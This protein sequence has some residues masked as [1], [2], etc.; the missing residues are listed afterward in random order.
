[1]AKLTFEGAMKRLEAIVRELETGDLGLD[2]A[3]KRFQEGIKLSRFCSKKLDESEKK[4]TLLLQ[5][6]TGEVREEPFFA[7]SDGPSHE[8]PLDE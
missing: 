4:V 2:D 8:N 6:D 1:M 7:E 5:D 3:L